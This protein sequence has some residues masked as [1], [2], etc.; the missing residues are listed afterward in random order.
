MVSK[1]PKGVNLWLFSSLRTRKNI[2]ATEC[3]TLL[4]AETFKREK[5]ADAGL[6][7]LG[8]F[9]VSGQK[10]RNRKENEF[11]TIFGKKRNAILDGGNF[12]GKQDKNACRL[13]I[14]GSKSAKKLKYAQGVFMKSSENSFETPKGCLSC[15]I[16]LGNHFLQVGTKKFLRKNFGIFLSENVV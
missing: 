10:L 8:T 2:G 3:R 6:K 11:S 7:P 9:L 12:D 16:R 5:G 13:Y 1:K 4:R 15:L 14:I